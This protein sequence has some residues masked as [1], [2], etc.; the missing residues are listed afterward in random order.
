MTPRGYPTFISYIKKSTFFVITDREGRKE[1]NHTLAVRGLEELF[2]TCA[3]VSVFLLRREMVF[4][5]TYST[6]LE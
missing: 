3:V 1:T 5:V 4:G 6:Y 2:S